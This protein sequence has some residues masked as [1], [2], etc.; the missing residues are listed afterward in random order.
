MIKKKKSD[1]LWKYTDLRALSSF[2]ILTKNTENNLTEFC[3]KCWVFPVLQVSNSVNACLYAHWTM[4]IYLEQCVYAWQYLLL[5]T[6]KI[7]RGGWSSFQILQQCFFKSLLIKTG[8]LDHMCQNYL[9]SGLPQNIDSWAPFQS[10]RIKWSGAKI[11]DLYF[12]K[13]LVWFDASLSLRTAVSVSDTV[14]WERE[15]LKLKI[16]R[17][18]FFLS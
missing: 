10:Y 5:I 14:G 11:Q 15:N 13:L 8:L 4:S 1:N 7:H 16:R 17:V 6:Q 12:N 9:G 2:S 18:D 3:M